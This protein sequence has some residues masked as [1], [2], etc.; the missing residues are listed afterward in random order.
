MSTD[1]H[2]LNANISFRNITNENGG[3]GDDYGD[4]EQQQQ[5]QKKLISRKVWSWSVHA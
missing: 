5:Q 4:D 2:Q 1:D 3:H